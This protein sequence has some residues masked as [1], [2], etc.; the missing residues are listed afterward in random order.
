MTVL[1]KPS[2]HKYFRESNVSLRVI[3]SQVN[4]EPVGK[5]KFGNVTPKG[6]YKP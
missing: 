1:T 6:V 2:W 5:K 3:Y 4:C